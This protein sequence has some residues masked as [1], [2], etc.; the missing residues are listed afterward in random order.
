MYLIELM[1][2]QCAETVHPFHDH[3]FTKK[4]YFL[5]PSEVYSVYGFYLHLE[6]H[7]LPHLMR[8][9]LPTGLIVVTSWASFLIDPRTVPG[10]MTL[11]VTLLLVLINVSI[12]ECDQIS[13]DLQAKRQ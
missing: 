8:T 1:V 13:G 4:G 3:L 12:G 2:V 7:F 10:R 11:L 6:R 9:Y 5:R